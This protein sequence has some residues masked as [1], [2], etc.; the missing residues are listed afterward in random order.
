M[1]VIGK[2]RLQSKDKFDTFYDQEVYNEDDFFVNNQIIKDQLTAKEQITGFDNNGL[3]ADL[4]KPVKNFDSLNIDVPGNG[5]EIKVKWDDL[6]TNTKPYNVNVWLL[7]E[8]WEEIEEKEGG[9][10]EY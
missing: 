1:A 10:N 9:E 3:P 7:V 2:A 4:V 5:Q 6:K 8:E